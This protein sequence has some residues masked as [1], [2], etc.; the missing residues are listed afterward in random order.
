MTK[1][2]KILNEKGIKQTWLAKKIGKTPP[3]LNRWVK[4]RITPS[5]DIMH[6]ISEALGISVDELFFN[7]NDKVN[8]N[9]NPK[10]VGASCKK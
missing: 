6:R 4:G 7:D 9:D 1:L 2:E 5:Y 8:T 3:E 10:A